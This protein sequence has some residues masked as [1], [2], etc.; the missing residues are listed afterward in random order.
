RFMFIS[1]NDSDEWGHKGE[2]GSYVE[3]L[4]QYDQWLKELI[5]TLEQ[6]GEYG[7]HT[8]LLVTTDHGRGELGNW[9]NHG[10]L[11]SDSKFI[12]LYGR[13]PYTRKQAVLP[14][15]RYTHIDIRPTIEAALRLTPVSCKSC[16]RVIEEVVGPDKP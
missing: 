16:G 6:M 10:P 5:M 9:K 11:I 1:L 3:S 2:Y 4:R 13:S 14:V 8:T 7:E 12:W 15:E